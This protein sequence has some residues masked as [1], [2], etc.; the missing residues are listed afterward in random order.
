M[1][2]RPSRKDTLAPKEIPCHRYCG[3]PFPT[4]FDALSSR[5]RGSFPARLVPV[6]WL[7]LPALHLYPIKFRRRSEDELWLCATG[8]AGG[9]PHNEVTIVEWYLLKTVP[10]AFHD[11]EYVFIL[12]LITRRWMKARA[13][14]YRW[15]ASEEHCRGFGLEE[16][17]CSQRPLLLRESRSSNLETPCRTWKSQKSM[18]SSSKSQTTSNATFCWRQSHSGLFRICESSGFP[19]QGRT[20]F[21]STEMWSVFSSATVAWSCF[22]SWNKHQDF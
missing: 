18:P 8:F 21:D 6:G 16:E 12:S 1:P 9:S 2:N 20:S 10:W 7:A 13:R 3:R 14:C 15:K 17:K 5:L 11:A 4:H 22:S 19:C